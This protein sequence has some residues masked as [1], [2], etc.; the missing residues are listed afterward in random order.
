MKMNSDTKYRNIGQ[1]GSMNILTLAGMILAAGIIAFDHL[2]M[3]LP[4]WLAVTLYSTAVI[5]FVTGMAAGQKADR[6]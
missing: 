5:L 6:T 4:N 2:I 3:P 1:K